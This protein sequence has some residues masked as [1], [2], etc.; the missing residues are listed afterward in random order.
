MFGGG[1]NTEII[2]G[3]AGVDIGELGIDRQGEAIS[4]RGSDIGELDFLGFAFESSEVA[5]TRDGENAQTISI[6]ADLFQKGWISVYSELTFVSPLGCSF[7]GD[8]AGKF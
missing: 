8:L 3:G 2:S 1:I 4:R 5:I 6:G 7:G